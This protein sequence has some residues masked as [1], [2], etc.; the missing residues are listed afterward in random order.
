MKR[1]L[2]ANYHTHAPYCRHAAGTVADYAAEAY[3]AGIRTLG[4]SD[5]APYPFPDG[6]YSSFRMFPEDREKYVGDVLRCRGEYAGKMEIFLGYE[7][8]Y[9]PRHFADMIKMINETGCDYVIL[10]QHFVKN[11]YDGFYSGECTDDKKKLREYVDQVC[12]AME[13]GVFSYLAHPDLI[14]FVGDDK[15]YEKQ[16]GRLC[17]VAVKTETP[18]EINLNGL[19]WNGH[20]PNGKFLEIASRYHPDFVIGTD[21][22]EPNNF[23]RSREPDLAF[24]LAKK[25]GLNVLDKIKLKKPVL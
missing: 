6:Y 5:H 2:T 13:T 22:H 3:K 23:A 20:Y 11:E 15:A 16:M 9:Y 14:H 12:E 8:E 10:G 19:R 18:L 21:A 1:K 4:F 24:E 25:Y 7:A 17:E